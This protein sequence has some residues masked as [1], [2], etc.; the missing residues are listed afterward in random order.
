MAGK[1][2]TYNS[3]DLQTSS[4]VM[5]G[6][7]YQNLDKNLSITR[8][9]S[10]DI[11]KYI[12]SY[13][14]NKKIVYT[15]YIKGSSASDAESKLDDL[16]KNVLLNDVANLDIEYSGGT[17]RYRCVCQSV[18]L[19]GE[20]PAL[21]VKN[22]KITFDTIEPLGLDTFTNTINYLAETANPINKN[23]TFSGT[24]YTLPIYKVTVSSQSNM[25][26]L[27]IKS[28]QTNQEIIIQKTYAIND[29]IEIDTKNKTVKYN[30]VNSD[31]FG[32][33]P[34]VN[35]GA[36][37]LQFTATSS[38]HSLNIRIDYISRYL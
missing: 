23:I 12:E 1:N 38:S 21:D 31:Y 22:I 3:Y 8:I 24:Y 36:N 2:I 32:I 35:Q 11:N 13:V 15:G 19:D 28:V 30:N 6:L 10:T 7:E 29:V 25:T 27:S 33:F 14:A 20:T 18:E 17:R 4:I 34:L 16:K 9:S 37:D 5:T 26:G